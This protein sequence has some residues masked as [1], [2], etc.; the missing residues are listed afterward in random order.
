MLAVIR[1]RGRTGIREKAE[2]TLELLGTHRI[3]HMVLMNESPQINGML[4]EAKDYITWGEISRETLEKV[5]EHRAQMKG[6]K[7]LTEGII[8][9][10][11]GFSD[12]KSL[13][14][15]IMEGKLKFRDI[16]N[17]VPVIRL[18]PPV[19]GY[20]YIRKPF[21][22]GGTLGYRGSEINNLIEKMLGPEVVEY[23]KN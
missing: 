22:Q 8:K 13:A 23:G 11:T 18:H 5:L 9:E 7:P 21:K 10:S 15:A 17:I 4:Q 14:E 12:F 20:E 19:G 2:K 1:V 3:N 16:P 6:R